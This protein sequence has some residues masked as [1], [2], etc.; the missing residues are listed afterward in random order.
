[1]TRTT[2]APLALLGWLCLVLPPP[3]VAVLS[4]DI[5]F[6]ANSALSGRSDPGG[7]FQVS[8][9]GNPDLPGISQPG[10]N[11]VVARGASNA[12]HAITAAR[13]SNA[14][15]AA[16]AKIDARSAFSTDSY[17]VVRSTATMSVELR[18]SFNSFARAGENVFMSFFIPPSFLELSVSGE[19]PGIA[20][21]ARLR[22]RIQIDNEELFDFEAALV[23]SFANAP[24]LSQSFFAQL[25]SGIA[26][27]LAVATVTEGGG[28]PG[29]GTFAGDCTHLY[30][31][32]AITGTL[33]LGFFPA[34]SSA[35]APTFARTLTYTLFTEVAGDAKF[36]GAIAALNDPF[37]FT[38][39]PVQGVVNQ[40]TSTAVPLPPALLM[41]VP[42]IG[43]LSIVARQRKRIMA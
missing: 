40:F 35:A 10:F 28:A 32:P 21:Q 19:L 4:D 12:A 17:S 8:D 33:S 30:E 39:D 37:V 14:D 41:F 13:S 1:M 22:A 27:P 26:V 18:S 43:L 31:F 29:C 11:S 9:P 25:E 36:T 34:P 5:S 42:A 20:M 6:S 16:N 2:I 23:G 15:I 3:V 38:G 7:I 24:S